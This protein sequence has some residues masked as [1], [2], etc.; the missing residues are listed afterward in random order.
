MNVTRSRSFR[1]FFTAL[2]FRGSAGAYFSVLFGRRSRIFFRGYTA[3]RLNTDYRRPARLISLYRV[4]FPFATRQN[5]NF[6]KC[7]EWP[8][9]RAWISQCTNQT[10]GFQAL[11]FHRWRRSLHPHPRPLVTRS[12]SLSRRSTFATLC[13]MSPAPRARPWY[14][15]HVEQTPGD[16]SPP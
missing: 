3:T 9:V 13:T 11:P 2:A 8:R 12:A 10:F 1:L 4:V 16:G 14:W 6:Q 5:L 7:T 15:S